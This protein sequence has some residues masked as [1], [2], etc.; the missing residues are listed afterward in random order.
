M[1]EVSAPAG[2][3]LA[4]PITFT[5]SDKAVGPDEDYIQE[6]TMV[7]KKTPTPKVPTTP[8][9]PATPVKST[10]STVNAVKTGDETDWALWFA[11]MALL[12]VV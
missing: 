6:W 12:N 11:L 2:Y 3:E 9:T 8:V 1:Q 4:E 5:M 7:D 10:V